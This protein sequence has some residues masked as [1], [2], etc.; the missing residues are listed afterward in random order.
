MIHKSIITLKLSFAGRTSGG[1]GTGPFRNQ[2]VAW[3]YPP[4]RLYY[5]YSLSCK[6]GNCL[7]HYWVLQNLVFHYFSLGR[8]HK[9][10]Q[11]IHLCYRWKKIGTVFYQVESNFLSFLWVR[12]A[13]LP[14]IW[15]KAHRKLFQQ[16]LEMHRAPSAGTRSFICTNPYPVPHTLL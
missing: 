10:R 3:H 2:C 13:T 7:Q 15:R 11:Q 1:P 4:S 12:S 9:Y 16:V 6:A 8:N 5:G 14:I